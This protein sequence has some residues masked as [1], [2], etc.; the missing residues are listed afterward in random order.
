MQAGELCGLSENPRAVCAGHYG[1]IARG[2]TVERFSHF[3][4]RPVDQRI[5]ASVGVR[6]KIRCQRAY[7]FLPATGLVARFRSCSSAVLLLLLV[8]LRA[9]SSSSSAVVVARPG[10]LRRYGVLV[11][12][13]G[14][15]QRFN[16][17]HALA[18]SLGMRAWPRMAMNGASDCVR[19]PQDDL[20]VA[21]RGS[22]YR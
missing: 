19:R 10:T 12:S 22:E 9:S 14:T 20:F 6:A 3:A 11:S 5:C 16:A 7:H 15:A 18:Q 17:Y 2:N 8:G 13:E 4:H 1:V 21:S